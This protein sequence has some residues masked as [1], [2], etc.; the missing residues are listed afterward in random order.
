MN[1][2]PIHNN[3]AIDARIM[4]TA[5]ELNGRM[6]ESPMDTTMVCVLPNGYRYFSDV[7]RFVAFGVRTDFCNVKSISDEVD[8]YTISRFS[9]DDSDWSDELPS[10][11]RIYIFI[12]CIDSVSRCVDI[13]KHYEY[14]FHPKEIHLR[15]ML[16]L[17][18]ENVVDERMELLKHFKTVNSL[19]RLPK[20]SEYCGNGIPDKNGGYSTPPTIYR[21]DD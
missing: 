6:I 4:S 20:G 9:R 11:N 16:E 3:L 10:G 1:Y 14:N 21:I 8:W 18:D 15:G 7:M 12:D 19:F 17:V 13:A 5:V 2:T